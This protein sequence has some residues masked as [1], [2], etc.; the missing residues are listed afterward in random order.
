MAAS[1]LRR[2]NARHLSLPSLVDT[3]IHLPK[4]RLVLVAD[5]QQADRGSGE[6]KARKTSSGDKRDSLCARDRFDGP[7]H[8]SRPTQ[9]TSISIADALHYRNGLII[10]LLALV[11]LRR[12]TLAALRIGKHLVQSGDQWSLDIPAEDIK[13]K[14]PLDY[15]DFSGAVG[16]YRPVLEPIPTSNPR[17]S[18]STIICGPPT[19]VDQCATESSMPLFGSAPVNA[20]GFPVNLHRFRLAAATLWSIR[21]PANVRGV[22]GPARSC[23]IRY[24]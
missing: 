11:P 20:L 21:D 7:R 3:S 1:K 19:E 13:T 23:I 17:C 9:P 24:D 14:R 4:R 22:Q 18:E 5:H 15:R 16:L 8:Q 2:H 12:R 6:T 10:A